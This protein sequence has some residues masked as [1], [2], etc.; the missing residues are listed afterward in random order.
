MSQVYT[1][2]GVFHWQNP[3]VTIDHS[4]TI[5]D[6]NHQVHPWLR[7]LI[8]DYQLVGKADTAIR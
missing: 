5:D 6:M 1:L 3:C 7:D 2:D 4:Y 8:C